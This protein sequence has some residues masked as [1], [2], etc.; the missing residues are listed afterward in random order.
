[1][2]GAY[3]P[4]RQRGQLG[5]GRLFRLFADSDAD[6]NSCL[7]VSLRLVEDAAEFHS[8]MCV[9]LEPPPMQLDLVLALNNFGLKIG[10]K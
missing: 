8:G 2:L 5:R 4:S 6:G 1:M 9:L 7:Q 10:R 3:Q